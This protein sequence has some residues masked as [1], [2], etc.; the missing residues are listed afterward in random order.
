MTPRT[1][2]RQ[3][4]QRQI[5]LEELRRSREHPT[6]AELHEAV[7]KRLPRISL[8]TVYR[9]LEL[10]ASA[11]KI[12]KLALS[13]QTMRYD[14]DL[15]RHYHI[16]CDQC[17]KIDD[18]EIDALDIESALNGISNEYEILGHRLEFIGIC[19]SCRRRQRSEGRQ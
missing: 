17:G 12:R 6:A 15:G 16:R 2:Q 11:G 7:R 10:L 4:R 14:G 9:N 18:V 5:I 1:S 19:K 8:G 13:G 3:T